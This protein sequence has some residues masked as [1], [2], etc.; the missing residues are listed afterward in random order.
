MGCTGNKGLGQNDGENDENLC[1]EKPE[2]RSGLRD[3]AQCF[4]KLLRDRELILHNSV[5]VYRASCKKS[6]RRISDGSRR[7][8]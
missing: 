4:R 6:I 1:F 7:V 3:A 8:I 2:S 5:C